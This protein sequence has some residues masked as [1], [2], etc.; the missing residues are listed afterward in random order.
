MGRSWEKEE[1][2][3]GGDGAELGL[4]WAVGVPV[5]GALSPWPNREGKEK[6]LSV[7]SKPSL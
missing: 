1:A 7:R 5:A 2:G 6:L 3:E 4:G